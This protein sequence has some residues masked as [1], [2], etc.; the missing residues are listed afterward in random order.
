MNPRFSNN[1]VFSTPARFAGHARQWPRRRARKGF[2]MME[3]ATATVII[4]VGFVAMLELLAAG[5]GTNARSAELTTAINLAANIHEA[6]VRTEYDQIFGLEATHD[7]AVDG[8]LATL[9]NMNG[10]S[11]VV[12]VSYVDPNLLTSDVPDD[13]DEPTARITVNIRRNGTTVYTT[14]WLVAASG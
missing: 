13:Q 14:S 12:D 8:E 2:T 5:T 7:P 11:Q 1:P 6:A 10:W 3:A 4:G 9:E